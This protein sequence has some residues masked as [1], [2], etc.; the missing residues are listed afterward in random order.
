MNIKFEPLSPNSD[1]FLERKWPKNFPQRSLKPRWK[2][3]KEVLADVESIGVK[4]DVYYI[5][6]MYIVNTSAKLSYLCRE[7]TGE[8]PWE[9]VRTALKATVLILQNP[10]KVHST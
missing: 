7:Y 8:T 5:Y 9:A 3:Y 2:T 4:V 1:I 10:D 6:P